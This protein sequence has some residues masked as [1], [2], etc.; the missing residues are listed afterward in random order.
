ML[1][2]FVNVNF[3]CLFI[4]LVILLGCVVSH[5]IL[6]YLNLMCIHEMTPVGLVLCW[7]L[8]DISKVICQDSLLASERNP[9]G[10]GDKGEV[11]CSYN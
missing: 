1:L 3:F 10:T 6:F 7:I 9:A 8:K 4:N 5:F 2:I 11:G